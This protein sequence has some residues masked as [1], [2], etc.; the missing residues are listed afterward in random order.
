MIFYIVFFIILCAS[1]YLFSLLAPDLR[2]RPRLRLEHETLTY[3]QQER[4]A[5]SLKIPKPLASLLEPITRMAYLK[6]L[7][8]QAEVLRVP[9]NLIV[10]VLFKIIVGMLVGMLTIRLFPLLYLPV[11][12]AV[13]FFLPDFIMWKRIE[14]KKN[15]IIKI[16]PETVDLLDMCIS[17]GQDFLSSVKWLIEK[18]EY[19]PFIEQLGVVVSEIQVGKTRAEALRD[20]ARRLKIPD[21]NSFVRTIIQ[22]ERMGTSI[23]EAFRNLSD[24]TRD[25]R[26]QIGERHAIKASLM[27]LFPLLFCILPAIMITVA[28][29]IIVKFSTG[30][31]IPKGT[32]F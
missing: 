26:F 23:E 25:R 31:L 14:A 22:A 9:V 32:G 21:V 10:L 8:D 24:D 27:I 5:I 16:F 30:E 29:P 6:N 17:A 18:S 3:N 13:G 15:L 19:N 1:I 7:R 2:S 20:M 4:K 12:L 11:G 28:G